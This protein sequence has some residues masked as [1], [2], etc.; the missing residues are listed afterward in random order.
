[1]ARRAADLAG[2]STDRLLARPATTLDM[3]AAHPVFSALGSER[4]QL[5]SPL[6]DALGRYL[7][8]LEGGLGESRQDCYNSAPW[9]GSSVGRAED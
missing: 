8:A 4:G 3:G 6:D 7:A 2:V 9:P 5:M 1:M